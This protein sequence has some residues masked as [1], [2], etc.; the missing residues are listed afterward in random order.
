MREVKVLMVSLMYDDFY[1]SKASSKS[2]LRIMLDFRPL[3]FEKGRC[4]L[5]Q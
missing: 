1:L 2:I 5:A 4:I 3:I